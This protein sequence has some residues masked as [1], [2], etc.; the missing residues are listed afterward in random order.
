MSGSARR[1]R[2]LSIIPIL[3][4]LINILAYNHHIIMK[5]WM[6]PK[7]QSYRYSR[8]GCTVLRFGPDFTQL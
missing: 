2:A 1:R 3:V 8:R 7:S 5:L 4:Y 6:N